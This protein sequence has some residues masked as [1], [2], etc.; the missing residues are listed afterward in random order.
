MMATIEQRGSTI[1]LLNLADVV[2]ARG[3]RNVVHGVSIEVHAGQVTAMLGPNGAG[4]SSIALAMSGSSNVNSASC[5]RM[6][7]S[8]G[9]RVRRLGTIAMS[10]N[11]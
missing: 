6:S 11:P 7:T 8:S 1:G 9:S 10:S 2:V 5:Q 3:P 4:K